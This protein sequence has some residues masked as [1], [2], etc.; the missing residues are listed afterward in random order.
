MKIAILPIIAG[1]SLGILGV[2]LVFF[3]NPP[4]M[5][6]CAACFT[7][8]I[9]GAIG[10]HNA[11]TLAY[12][13]V[14]IIAIVIGAML[15]ALFFKEFKPQASNSGIIKFTL[16]IFAMIGAL[17]FLGC[18]WRMILRLGAGDLSALSGLVGFVCGILAGVF[19]IK[20]GYSLGRYTAT[21]PIVALIFPLIMLGLFALLLVGES[22]NIIN[23][24]SKGP[25]SLH[26]PIIISLIAGLF[27]GVILQRS[28]FCSISAVSNVV[29]FKD[30]YMLQGLLAFLISAFIANLAFGYF[31]L[32]FTNQP[33]A[34]N[35]MLWNFLGMLLAGFAFSIG[36]GC[37][38]RQLVLAGEGNSD[39]GIFLL[40]LL[41]GG[42]L[43]HNFALAS[44]PAGITQNAPFAVIGGI[45]FCLCVAIFA[46]D[47]Q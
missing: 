47:K 32:G 38:G 6:I 18:P 41:V 19:F 36:G 17:V 22:I 5:G 33:I 43:A 25:G 3:G 28:R 14:E 34:H 15:S 23:F 11:N 2:V 40:G 45:I 20:R 26:A 1:I 9:A 29:L 39:A 16:G 7:R 24:S 8:D 37:P 27:L 12:I 10:L 31:N 4:N 35:D 13:R 46:K 21:H 42:G 44:S 30:S